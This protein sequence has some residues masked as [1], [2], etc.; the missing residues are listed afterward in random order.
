[1]THEWSLLFAYVP[2]EA[3]SKRLKP[4][5]YLVLTTDRRQRVNRCADSE[6]A[7]GKCH[8][9]LLPQKLFYPSSTDSYII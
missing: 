9:S 8:V 7:N 3:P 5:A 2:V 6:T 1:M 4:V